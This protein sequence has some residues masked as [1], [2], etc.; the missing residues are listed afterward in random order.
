MTLAQ[1][2]ESEG[3]ALIEGVLERTSLRPAIE[4]LDATGST[5]G[6]AGRRNVADDIPA[7]RGLAC[8]PLL[9]A[10]AGQVLGG[11]PFV[12]R[13]LL[14]D[15]TPGANWSLGWHQD[16]VIA[17]R[18]KVEAPG[19][20]GWSVKAGVPHVHPPAE[21]LERMVTLRVHLD[22]CGEDNGPLRVI[23]GSHRNGR[24][25]DEAVAEWVSKSETICPL[26]AGG[27][28]AMR[29]LIMHASS[30]ARTPQHRRVLHLEFAADLLPDGLEWFERI[31]PHVVPA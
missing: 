16:N 29:P 9:H 23:P 27:I 2:I 13:I 10:L 12:V 24:L 21:I 18:G 19:F 14:F 6:H 11:D 30:P 7:V 4:A 26:R 28:L 5:N 22:D 1:R 20:F 3:F 8:S 31:A 17:V 25:T 15:K